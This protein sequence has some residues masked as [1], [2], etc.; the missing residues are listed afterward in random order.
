M[1]KRCPIETDT[2]ILVG[3]FWFG[4]GEYGGFTKCKNWE[5]AESQAASKRR[6]GYDKPGVSEVRILHRTLKVYRPR[7]SERV[8][9]QNENRSTRTH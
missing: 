3:V 7:E 9:K 8:E 6:L 2:I 5:D 1:T 4:S